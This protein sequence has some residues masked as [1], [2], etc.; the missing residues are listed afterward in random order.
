MLNECGKNK[1]CDCSWIKVKLK[2]DGN[3]V[4]LD[5]IGTQVTITGENFIKTQTLMAGSGYLNQNSKTLLFG[6]RDLK[7]I[8]EIK[9]FY[10]CGK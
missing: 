5:A 3:K 10:F 6:L 8:D 2:G 1:E 9:I 4:N 7:K